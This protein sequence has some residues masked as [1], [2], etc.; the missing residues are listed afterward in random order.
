MVYH[1]F[2]QFK[3]NNAA[4][5]SNPNGAQEQPK[6]VT[7]S[8]FPASGS[9][10]AAPLPFNKNIVSVQQEDLALKKHKFLN[11]SDNLVLGL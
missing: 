10:G 4:M 11:S 3:T 5:N 8:S 1:F 2:N 7:P 9:N 6:L